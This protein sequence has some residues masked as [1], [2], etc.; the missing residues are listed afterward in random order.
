VDFIA[1]KIATKTQKYQQN[2][3]Y[4]ETIILP[5]KNVANITI[6]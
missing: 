1:G 4:A 2:A 5:T 6:T 3:H